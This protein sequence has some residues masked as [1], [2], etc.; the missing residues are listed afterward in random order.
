MIPVSQK[1]ISSSVTIGHRII[2]PQTFPAQCSRNLDPCSKKE[3]GHAD[4]VFSTGKIHYWSNDCASK[5][6]F[7]QDYQCP[8]QCSG[9]CKALE[10]KS[11]FQPITCSLSLSPA[12]VVASEMTKLSETMDKLRRYGNNRVSCH[13]DSA[14]RIL[15]EAR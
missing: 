1:A 3:Q 4:F 11:S 7:M 15:L 14:L 10:R 6:S 12:S 5:L 9:H 13:P 8:G 2:R